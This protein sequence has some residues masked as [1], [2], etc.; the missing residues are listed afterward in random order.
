[1]DAARL[2]VRRAARADLS[3]IVALYAADCVAAGRPSVES[4]DPAPYLAA[5]DEIEA[6]PRTALYVASL[7]ERVVGALQLV[8][9]RHLTYRGSRVAQVEAVHVAEDMRNR[10]IGARLMHFAIDEA[11]RAGCQRMQLTSNKR[12]RDAHRFYERLGFVASHEGMKLT[13]GNVG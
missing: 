9:L 3:A 13:L 5:F 7:E 12:R 2:I 4:D 1:V 11:M 8:L 6:D 10:G